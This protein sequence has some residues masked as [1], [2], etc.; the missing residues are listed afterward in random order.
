[1]WFLKT[2]GAFISELVYLL[3]LAAG[4]LKL[5]K[6]FKTNRSEMMRIALSLCKIKHYLNILTRQIVRK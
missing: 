5:R 6:T 3:Q 1:M 2:L 4:C